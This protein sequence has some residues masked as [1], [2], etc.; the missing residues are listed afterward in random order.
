MSERPPV[1]IVGEAP[2][3]SGARPFEFGSARRRLQQIFGVVDYDEFDR[4]YQMVNLWSSSIE[5]NHQ[6]GA[7]DSISALIEFARHDT[8]FILC[9]RLVQE[10]F[11]SWAFRSYRL[12]QPRLHKMNFFTSFTEPNGFTYVVI[13]HPSGRCRWWNDPVKVKEAQFFL[14][15]WR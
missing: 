1:V 9:G 10:A 13:P 12:S 2:S 5:A 7:L 14:R 11:T 8:V 3:R 4:R 15:A 6:L